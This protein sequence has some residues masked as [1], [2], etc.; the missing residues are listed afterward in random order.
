MLIPDNENRLTTRRMLGLI[1]VWGLL[2]L[3]AWLG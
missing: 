3:F 1:A 2:G